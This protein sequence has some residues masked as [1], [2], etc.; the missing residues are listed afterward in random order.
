MVLKR[1]IFQQTKHL[2]YTVQVFKDLKE[3][4]SPIIGKTQI[5]YVQL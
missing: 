2:V 3:D 4:P 5:Q 1:V